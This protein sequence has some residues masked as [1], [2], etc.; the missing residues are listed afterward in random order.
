MHGN[1]QRRQAHL[2]DPLHI[3]VAEVGKGDVI[4]HQERQAG[5]VILE[6]QALAHTLGQL[7]D[8]AKDAL[9][10]AALLPIHQ[11]GL[12]IQAQ[13]F[14]LGLFNDQLHLLTVPFQHQFYLAVVAVKFIIQHVADDV[15]VDA[16]Q[17]IA[18]LDAVCMGRT[19]L[20]DT[21]N[22]RSHSSSPFLLP[23]F[24]QGYFIYYTPFGGKLQSFRQETGAK[25]Y[26]LR[27]LQA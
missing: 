21:C 22:L 12:K 25:I 2:D 11:V 20:V 13:V 26:H 3:G 10:G 5:V 27:I 9:V 4:A 16:H 8:E 7:I 6:I 1:I 14:A 19:A 17:A 15:T 18:G 24:G 23:V